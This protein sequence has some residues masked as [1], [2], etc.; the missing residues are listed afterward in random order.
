MGSNATELMVFTISACTASASM[1]Y[2]SMATF[3]ASMIS[4]CT[5]Q[6]WDRN[7]GQPDHGNLDRWRGAAQAPL[8]RPSVFEWI[9]VHI[10]SRDAVQYQHLAPIEAERVG[11]CKLSPSATSARAAIATSW[12]EGRV[13]AGSL[14]GASSLTGG[15][16]LTSA[17]RS[18]PAT[19]S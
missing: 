14:T 17:E 19:S 9:G 7:P 18:P 6:A 12:P 4:A 3:I 1:A 5:C 2:W 15:G 16:T 8:A 11:E 10:G 13:F